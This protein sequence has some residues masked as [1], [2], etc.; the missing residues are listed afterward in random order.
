MSRLRVPAAARQ[1]LEGETLKIKAGSIGV[2]CATKK[3]LPSFAPLARRARGLHLD[4]AMLSAATRRNVFI[5]ALCQ[6][7]NVTGLSLMITVSA[8]TGHK[9]SSDPALST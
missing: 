1:T 3:E 2:S 5:L 8:V 4:A 7:L 6:A 9:L